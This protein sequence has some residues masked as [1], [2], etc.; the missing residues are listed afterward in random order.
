MANKKSDQ[1]LQQQIH[2]LFKRNK[3]FQGYDLKVQVVEGEVQLQG[4]VDVLQEKEQAEELVHS[5]PGINGV[6]NAISISTDGAINDK[7]V[8]M[9]VQEELEA[10]TEVDLHHIGME[11]VNSHGTVV[12][13]GKTGD[14]AEIEAAVQAASKARGVTKVLDQ[15]KLKEEE[16][17]LEA[18]FHSQV[19]ND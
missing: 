1:E 5:I 15:V 17:T 18:L 16:P 7:D 13:K 10:N 12:L 4:I 9:E 2:S 6:A 8:I 19:N 3:N 11:K 14:P